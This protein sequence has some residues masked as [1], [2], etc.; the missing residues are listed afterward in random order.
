MPIHQRESCQCFRIVALWIGL[1]RHIQFIICKI[2]HFI[3]TLWPD[4]YNFIIAI[5]YVFINWEKYWYSIKKRIWK[6]KHVFIFYMHI[7]FIFQKLVSLTSAP[8]NISGSGKVCGCCPLWRRTCR[9]PL[10]RHTHDWGELCTA[11]T[12]KENRKLIIACTMI[13]TLVILPTIDYTV[14]ASCN[15]GRQNRSTKTF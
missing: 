4:F 1:Q 2:Y 5:P 15:S 10:P 6:K 3:L 8:G 12:V 14:A 11:A 9:H 13:A 7:L